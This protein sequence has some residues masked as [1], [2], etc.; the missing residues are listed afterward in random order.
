MGQ[1]IYPVARQLLIKTDGGGS[2]GYRVR[3]WHREIQKLANELPLPLQVCHFLPRTS[4]WNKIEHRMF[5]YITANSRGHSLVQ[6]FDLDWITWNEPVKILGERLAVLHE[7]FS[8]GSVR[9]LLIRGL[10]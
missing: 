8:L 6:E 4:K 2:N 1:P 10:S 9:L 5:C 7:T 3:L